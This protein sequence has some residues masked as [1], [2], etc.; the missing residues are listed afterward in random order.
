MRSLL[1]RWTRPRRAGYSQPIEITVYTR[2]NCCCC[3]KALE[4]LERY[5]RRH[6]LAIRT[7][8]VDADPALAERYGTMVPVVSVAGKVRFKGVVNPVLLERLLTAERRVE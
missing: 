3:H 7:V 5:R 6:R 8:D 4:L 2:A 1:S